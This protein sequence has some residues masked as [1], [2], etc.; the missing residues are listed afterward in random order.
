[1]VT[2]VQTPPAR[3]AG[4]APQRC[5]WPGNDP[6]YIDYHDTEWGVPEWD[7]RALFEKLVLDGFQAG[8]SWITILRKRDA[9]R[10]AFDGFEPARIVRYGEADVARLMGDAGIVRNQAKI[11]NTI[12]MA[13]YWLDEQERGGFANR[14]WAF[15]DGEPQQGTYANKTEVPTESAAS[16]AMAK[17]LR[18][19]GL[20]FCGPTILYAFMEAV[21]MVN[22]H[23]ISCFR[24]PECRALADVRR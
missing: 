19:Q 11:R 15:V 23:V 9:F 14:L 1:M 6:L 17:H 5:T 22:D 2:S 3:T 10:R 20:A 4:Q 12:K 24:H 16:N 7:D 13:R 8:L 21:G 18:A